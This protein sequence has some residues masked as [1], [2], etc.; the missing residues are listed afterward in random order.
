MQ[1][2]V[3]RID[4]KN[5]SNELE[6]IGFDK[7][8]VIEASKKHSYMTLKIQNLPPYT[9]TI[10]KQ[11][12]L[13]KGTDA[14][15]NRDVLMHKKEVSDL[16]LSGTIKQLK[17]ISKSLSYQ[18]FNLK[19]IALEIDKEIE[20]YYKKN[21]PEIMGILN[22]TEDSFS[23]DGILDINTAIKK[24]ETLIIE[25]ANIIDLGAE[26]KRP[27]ANKIDVEDEIKRLKPVV[28]ELKKSGYILSID[29]RNHKTADIMLNSGADI[30]NDVSGLNYDKEMINVI[31]NYDKEIVI[32]HSKGTPE[33][34]DELCKYDNL[35]DEIYNEL[36][37]KIEFLNSKGIE[38]KRIIIDT[39][40]GF[41]KN[42]EQNFELL[43]RIREFNSLNVRHLAG[44]SRK[45]FL[46]SLSDDKNNEEFDNIT[47]LASFYLIQNN[48]DIFR[49]HNVK[50][51]KTAIEFYKKL[52]C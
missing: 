24:A 16:I 6:L 29:T 9:A 11:T 18:P 7:S 36:Y 32:M 30:I 45:R 14:G 8:Y 2:I 50:K 13:S 25:G 35:A 4:N 17:E 37:K 3:K 20:L 41:A 31:K 12:A 46:Q 27:N 10:I 39:G 43:K 42:I 28:I 47:M 34:M 21:E 49:V 33:N 52:T 15:L 1:F 51:T 5:I 22:L 44:V 48:V 23:R 38:N 40:F 19:E 26:S